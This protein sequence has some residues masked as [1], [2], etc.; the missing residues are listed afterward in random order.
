MI[1][2]GTSLGRVWLWG[3][4][5][6]PDRPL[7]LAISG[8]FPPRGYLW[9]LADDTADWLF[10]DLPGFHSLRLDETSIAA[11][12]AAFDEALERV[13]PGRDVVA[14]GVSTGA[15][16]AMSLQR[17]RSVVAIEPFF[18]TAPLWAFHEFL[19][20]QPVTEAERQWSDAIFGDK[21]YRPILRGLKVPCRAVVGDMPLEPRRLVRGLPSLTSSEDRAA[22]R[23]HPLVTLTVEPG[24]HELP[25]DAIRRAVEGALRPSERAAAREGVDGIAPIR[26]HGPA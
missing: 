1:D 22:L 9:W 4:P 5:M 17:A 26:R 12:A 8:A 15:L 25:R 16:V 13:A 10:A 14:L 2:V 20:R 23:A 7:V 3:R 24:G 11:F 18:R 21:D 6:R 19:A